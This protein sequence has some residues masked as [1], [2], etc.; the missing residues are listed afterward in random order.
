[1]EMWKGKRGS[2]GWK[3]VHMDFI[4]DDDAVVLLTVL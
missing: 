1:M 2:L 4:C 3:I